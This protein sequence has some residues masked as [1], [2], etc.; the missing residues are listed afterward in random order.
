[1]LDQTRRSSRRPPSPTRGPSR[2][3]GP[4]AMRSQ[5]QCTSVAHATTVHERARR[6]SAASAAT[7]PAPLPEVDGRGRRVFTDTITLAPWGG[8]PCARHRWH[9]PA[10]GSTV[11]RRCPGDKASTR[12][13]GSCPQNKCGLDSRQAPRVQ[14]VF[15][16][17]LQATWDD[18]SALT[19]AIG[20]GRSRGQPLISE[21]VG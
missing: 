8:G 6:R 2:C 13:R 5:T 21:N 16:V 20:H 11:S 4:R 9:Q 18:V 19:T 10:S 1:M 14:D 3:S 12:L 15:A 7:T 17:A